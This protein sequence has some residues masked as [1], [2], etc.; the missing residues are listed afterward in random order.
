MV[1]KKGGGGNKKKE[2]AQ[3][4]HTTR[5]TRSQIMLKA[6]RRP[7]L[8]PDDLC[9]AGPITVPARTAQVVVLAPPD[10]VSGS[11]PHDRHV[12]RH[13]RRVREPV[14]GRVVEEFDRQLFLVFSERVLEV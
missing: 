7:N 14:I 2:K 1:Y 8:L 4:P 13:G 6:I 10:D 11:L 3:R 9:P 12:L 5:C